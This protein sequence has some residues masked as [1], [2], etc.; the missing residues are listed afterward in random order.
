MSQPHTDRCELDRGEIIVASLI[1]SRGN[2]SEVL[3]FV[4]EA[5]DEVALHIE[6][7]TQHWFDHALRYGADVGSGTP[8]SVAIVP[9][10]AKSLVGD[11][12]CNRA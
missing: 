5:F 4:K 2:C 9:F 3:E 8:W 11:L 10:L 1:G 12:L 6:E 7:V